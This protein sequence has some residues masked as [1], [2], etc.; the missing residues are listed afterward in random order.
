MYIR[1]NI[2][3]GRMKILGVEIK[4]PLCYVYT[5]FKVIFYILAWLVNQL[6]L[7]DHLVKVNLE[8]FLK[9]QLPDSIQD[10]S[11]SLQICIGN[12]FPG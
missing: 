9:M 8:C 5:V 1:S 7:T 4:S 3:S 11:I 2:F 10:Q 12:M 6:F